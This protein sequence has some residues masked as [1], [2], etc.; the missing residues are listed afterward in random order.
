ML[1]ALLVIR[2]AQE[3][4]VVSHDEVPL[5]QLVQHLQFLNLV[6]FGLIDAVIV[7]VKADGYIC[8]IV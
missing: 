4:K 6:S 1:L 3:T 8:S 7:T 2:R 5:L